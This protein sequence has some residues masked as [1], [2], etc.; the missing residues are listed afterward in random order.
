MEDAPDE[1]DPLVSGRVREQRQRAQAARESARGPTWAESKQAA[2][3]PQCLFLFRFCLI[4]L[5]V[6]ICVINCVMIQK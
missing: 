2:R 1:R 6:W 4:M 3:T 5:N